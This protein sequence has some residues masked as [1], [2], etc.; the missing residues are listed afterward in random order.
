MK[1]EGGENHVG[2]GERLNSAMLFGN[3]CGRAF[4]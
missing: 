3:I 1:E 4:E 2:L